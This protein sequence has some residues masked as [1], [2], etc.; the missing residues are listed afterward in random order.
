MV[1]SIGL[2]KEETG[3]GGGSKMGWR[4]GR[5]YG[6]FLGGN[7]PETSGL[8]TRIGRRMFDLGRPRFRS[9]TDAHGRCEEDM[10]T[11]PDVDEDGDIKTLKQRLSV[12]TGIK[13]VTC[14]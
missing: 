2:V 1:L 6:S 9:T 3:F 8:E 12:V 10:A 14:P 4:D 11:R 7:A 13:A 5:K